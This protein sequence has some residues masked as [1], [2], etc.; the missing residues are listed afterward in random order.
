MPRTD[1]RSGPQLLTTAECA[2]LLNVSP[3]TV[4]G[5]IKDKSIPFVTLPGNRYRIPQQALLASLGGNY[6]LAEA[7]L[8]AAQAD[9]RDEVEERLEQLQ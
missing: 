2:Q 7:E 1:S 8:H 6:S 5:W 3:R 9:D 4:Q